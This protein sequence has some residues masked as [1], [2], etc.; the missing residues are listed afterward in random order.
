MLKQ[1]KYLWKVRNFFRSRFFNFLRHLA[2]IDDCRAILVNLVREQVGYPKPRE[3]SEVQAIDPPYPEIGHRGKSDRTCLRSDIIFVTGRFRSGS[4]L[5]WNLF[6]NIP[7]I[8]SYYEPFNE[9]R[10]FDQANRGLHV[11]PTHLKV[12]EYWAE[13]DGLAALGNYYSEDW[14][15]RQLYMNA[16]AWKPAMQRYIE[17]LIES[18]KGRPVLQ[19]NRVDLRLPWLRSC[20]PHTKILHIFRHPRDQWCSTLGGNLTSGSRLQ[21]Q[22]FEQYDGFYLLTWG[23][24]LHNYFP[25]LTLDKESHPYELF[26]QIWKLSYL[27]GR[28]YSNLSISLEEILSNPELA[29][30]RML[31]DLSVEGYDLA[32]L[33]NLVTPV[34]IGKW[35]QFADQQWFR[36]IEEKV[37]EQIAEYFKGESYLVSNI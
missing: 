33:V 25:F 21:L 29:I 28:S 18:A 12:G 1:H 37:D 8:T 35:K 9:R 23:Q 13:Y 32:K 26:Y 34:P 27:F 15:R 3:L 22:D 6:R 4:T 2:G 14:T 30:K 10:W 16:R 17:I 20:F 11:D 36:T 19:F 7:N 24:D 5:I 31:S